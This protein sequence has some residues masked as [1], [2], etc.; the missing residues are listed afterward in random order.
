MARL[1]TTFELKPKVNKM[2]VKKLRGGKN[3]KVGM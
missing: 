3:L 2:S 1:S